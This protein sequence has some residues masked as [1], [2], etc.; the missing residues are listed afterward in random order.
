MKQ[1]SLVSFC[2]D[3]AVPIC[4]AYIKYMPHT[5]A[6]ISASHTEIEDQLFIIVQVENRWY[7]LLEK[8]LNMR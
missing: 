1:A 4:M 2:L 5:A 7:K 8:R 6:I 3:Y